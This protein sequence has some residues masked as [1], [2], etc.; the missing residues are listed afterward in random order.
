M[1]IIINIWRGT[2]PFS[3]GHFARVKAETS[4]LTL[5]IDYGY[6]TTSC[7][8]E[9]LSACHIAHLIPVQCHLCQRY[10]HLKHKTGLH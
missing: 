5:W 3:R 7:L 2:P 9:I 6:D 4:C 10:I 8:S 1:I